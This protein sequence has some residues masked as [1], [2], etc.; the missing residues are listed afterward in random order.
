MPRHLRTAWGERRMEKLTVKRQKEVKAELLK[1][2]AYRC[3]ICQQDLRRIL[4]SNICL[5]HDHKTGIVRGVLCRGCN[6]AE[7]KIKNLAA[8]YKKDLTILH[9]LKNLVS[10]TESHRIPQTEFL[11]ST[12]KT[13]EEK[14]A[15]R[16]KRARTRRKVNG[17]STT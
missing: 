17:K 13:E 12:H 2:Q 10:Y 8:R 14:R 6:G 1:E 5:D 3:A 15:L 4:K 7:G 16:N 9:W 11:H